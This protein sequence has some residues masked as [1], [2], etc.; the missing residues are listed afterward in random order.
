MFGVKDSLVVDLGKVDMETSKKYNVKEGTALMTYD[1]VL[2]TEKEAS[3]LRDKLSI[4][5]LDNLGRKCR[6]V[7]GLPVPDVD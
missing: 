3:D 6:I 5:A 1:F 7:D 2:V 4:E